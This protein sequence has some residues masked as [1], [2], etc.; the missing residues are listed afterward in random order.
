MR[1]ETHDRAEAMNE[2]FL[3]E[4]TIVKLVPEDD[5]WLIEFSC[6]HKTIFAIKPRAHHYSCAQCVNEYLEQVRGKKP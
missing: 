4:R 6:G 3:F 5:V 2:E 1:A